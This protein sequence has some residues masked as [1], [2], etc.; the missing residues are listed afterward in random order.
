[1]EKYLISII[2][3][4]FSSVLS[5]YINRIATKEKSNKEK[6]RFFNAVTNGLKANSISNINMLLDIYKSFSSLSSPTRGIP[7][8]NLLRELLTKIHQDVSLESEEEKKT[9]KKFSKKISEFIEEE[10][11]QSPFDALPAIEKAIFIDL[12]HFVESGDSKSANRK[13]FELVSVVNARIDDFVK[14]QKINKYSV[15]IAIIGITFT[16]I[17]GILS[18]LNF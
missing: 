18:L 3:S 9:I 1:M 14:Y 12:Q 16:I 13:L 11:S 10:E 4:L 7:L 15:P 17:F 6:E 2:A 8:L 5:Y